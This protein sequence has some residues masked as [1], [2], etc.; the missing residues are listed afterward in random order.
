M[1]T[2]LKKLIPDT[3]FIYIFLEELSYF[4]LSYLKQSKKS[5]LFYE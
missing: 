2:N 1:V 5:T 4:S 3:N